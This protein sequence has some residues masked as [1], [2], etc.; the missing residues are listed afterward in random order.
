MNKRRETR[1]YLIAVA[2][3]IYAV[4]AK[5]MGVLKNFHGPPGYRLAKK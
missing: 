4:P 3:G 1:E 5:K 2:G